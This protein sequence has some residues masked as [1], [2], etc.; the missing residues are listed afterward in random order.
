MI[1]PSRLVLAALTASMVAAFGCGSTSGSDTPSPFNGAWTCKVT[2]TVT[3]TEP[4]KKTSTRNTSTPVSID[5]DNDAL[6][7]VPLSF[8]DGGEQ[9]S[10]NFAT[11]GAS[12]TL[13][14]GQTCTIMVVLPKSTATVTGTFMTGSASVSGNTLS[15]TVIDSFS[16]K[17]SNDAGSI[18]IVGTE[19]STSTCTK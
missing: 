7:T 5:I 16:G 6:L 18:N 2:S 14:S 8:S 11:T 19:T 12:A 10:L 13:S 17:D 4:S 15:V 1:F 3:L 9:C